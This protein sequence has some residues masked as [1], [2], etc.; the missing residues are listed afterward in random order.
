[1]EI[2]KRWAASRA[3]SCRGVREDAIID[4]IEAEGI[5]VNAVQTGILN[6][7]C[8]VGCWKELPIRCVI[9]AAGNR[10]PIKPP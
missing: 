1:M 8:H 9:L 10:S 4:P 3:A 6:L 5:E 7:L 2:D